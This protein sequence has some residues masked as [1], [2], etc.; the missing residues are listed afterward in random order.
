MFIQVE[1]KDEVIQNLFDNVVG[2]PYSGWIKTFEADQDKKGNWVG[3]IQF[4]REQDQEATFKGRF[5]ITN[6]AVQKG[7][8]AIAKES[9]IVFGNLLA[10]D[11]DAVDADV[12][13]QFLVFGRE[14]YA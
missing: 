4:D 12:F 1:I 9:P 5:K 14:V 6:E 8:E 11:T 3:S 2:G 10:N 13:M 7:L